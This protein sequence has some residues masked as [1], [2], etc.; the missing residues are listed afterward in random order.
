MQKAIFRNVILQNAILQNAI[1]QNAIL[2]KAIL[3]KANLQKSILQKASL[4]RI[5]LLRSPEKFTYVIIYLKASLVILLII[6]KI[7]LSLI[8]N[9]CKHLQFKMWTIL[10][11]TYTFASF[12]LIFCL[13]KFN[14]IAT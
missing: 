2:R 12:I 3:Q 13:G 14:E 7:L 5:S 6:S 4:I 1:L 9:L 10:L 8:L 11:C